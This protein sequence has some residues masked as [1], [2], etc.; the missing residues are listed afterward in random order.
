MTEVIIQ[1]TPNNYFDVLNSDLFTG[2]RPRELNWL[3]QS[4]R[5]NN[6]T[7]QQDGLTEIKRKEK[8]E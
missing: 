4:E 2:N 5:R 6:K 1:N 3:E 8:D 7:T